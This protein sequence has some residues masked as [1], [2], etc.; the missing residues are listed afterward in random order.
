MKRLIFII[1]TILLTV[2]FS[3]CSNGSDT[4]DISNSSTANEQSSATQNQYSD[5][6]WSEQEI[7]TLFEA[8]AESNWTIIDCVRVADFA[9]DR[10]GVVLFVD[11]DNKHTNL[12]FMNAEGY[13][14]LC[15]TKAQ[16]STPAELKYCGNG[17]VTFMVQTD[18][19]V[20]YECKITFSQS[21]DRRETNFVL[22]DNLQDVLSKK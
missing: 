12:A 3:A 6:E 8:K 21:E 5:K 17:I 2:T 10:I 7:L 1:L 9:H 18:D 13:Y 20:A 11:N 14:A 22:E 15:G 4:P 19:G 16:L